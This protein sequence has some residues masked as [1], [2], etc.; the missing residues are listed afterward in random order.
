MAAITIC[1]N[2]GAPENKV[3]HCF[4]CFPIYFRIFHIFLWSTQSKALAWSIKQKEMFFCNSL[5]FLLIQRML[6][7]CS[8]VPLPFL[9]PAG[10]SG[11]YTDWKMEENREF[12]SRPTYICLLDLWISESRSVM[13]NSLQPNR[14]YSPW[15]SPGQNAGVGSLSLLQGSSQPR[16]QTQVS[17]I[18]GRFFI[19]WATRE[20]LCIGDIDS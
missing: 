5:A 13:S 8:L 4:H 3:W 1:S 16:D 7:I 15:N 17:R 11:S 18:A 19:S 20:A 12:R 9:N 10:I 2:F 14:L 6:P